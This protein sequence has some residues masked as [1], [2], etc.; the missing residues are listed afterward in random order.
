ME[1]DVAMEKRLAV[2]RLPHQGAGEKC[3]SVGV[4]VG[5]SEKDW[6][7]WQEEGIIIHRVVDGILIL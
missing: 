5:G 7:N 1:I 4:S 2:R 6:V 3:W